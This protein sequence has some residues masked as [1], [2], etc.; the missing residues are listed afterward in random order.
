MIH[1]A[2]PAVFLCSDWLKRTW[3]AESIRT[4][5]CCALARRGRN[6]FDIMQERAK[7][8]IS[9]R[10]TLSSIGMQDS[11]RSTLNLHRGSYQKENEDCFY[12]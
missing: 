9:T 2:G 5:Q 4:S 6:L 8:T 11:T 7:V 10:W 12:D 3:R 1:R